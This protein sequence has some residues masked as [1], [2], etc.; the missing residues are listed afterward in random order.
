MPKALKRQYLS[1]KERT[2]NH[3]IQKEI[4]TD[5]IPVLRKRFTLH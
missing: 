2:M 5:S 4:D 1:N 3:P